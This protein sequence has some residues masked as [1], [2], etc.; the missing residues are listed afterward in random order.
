VA[1]MLERLGTIK[2]VNTNLHVLLHRIMVKLRGVVQR[3]KLSFV[4][5]IPCSATLL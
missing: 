4:S 2:W 5:T 1:C 3:L